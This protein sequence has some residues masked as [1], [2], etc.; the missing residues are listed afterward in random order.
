VAKY[1]RRA[2]DADHLAELDAEGY[3]AVLTI[4]YDRGPKQ[5]SFAYPHAFVC[6]DGTTYW[7]KRFQ[8][9]SFQQ[10]TATGAPGAQ[11]GLVAERGD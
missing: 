8:H 6:S 11:E 10:D 5:P 2:M 9:G 1:V 4:A 3:T 7:I